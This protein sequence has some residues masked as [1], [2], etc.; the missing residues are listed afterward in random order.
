MVVRLSSLLPR[1][2]YPVED[3]GTYPTF[4]LLANA[5]GVRFSLTCCKARQWE[6]WVMRSL[7]W[8][9]AR[10]TS[11]FSSLKR[12]AASF[13]IF[14]TSRRGLLP[15]L[16]RQRPPPTRVPT[17]ADRLVSIDIRAFVFRI[18]RPLELGLQGVLVVHQRHSL[19]FG[20]CSPE[21][22]LSGSFLKRPCTYEHQ[23]GR[24]NWGRMVEL[25]SRHCRIFPVGYGGLSTHPCRHAAHSCFPSRRLQ[26]D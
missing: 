21:P 3:R 2:R 24:T 20:R 7:E 8:S 11:G 17:L 4:E 25:R 12:K 14:R 19:W 23:L 18:G 10:G 1:I 22:Q 9:K 26:L 16:T 15:W 6:K 13:G 5:L